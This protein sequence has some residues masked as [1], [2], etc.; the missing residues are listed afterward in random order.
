MPCERHGGSALY[1]IYQA[2][3][4]LWLAAVKMGGE[5]INKVLQY[6][7]GRLPDH[8]AL[9]VRPL[10]GHDAHH[11]VEAY[12]A[13]EGHVASYPRARAHL[14]EAPRQPEHRHTEHAQE[15]R[16]KRRA[17]VSEE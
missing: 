13:V 10:H 4:G 5:G 9:E 14:V 3:S 15:A 12:A 17:R 8:A 16:Q 7:E 1:S 2:Y 6:D 11:H